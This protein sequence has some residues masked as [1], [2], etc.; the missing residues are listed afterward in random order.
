MCCCCFLASGTKVARKGCRDRHRRRGPTLGGDNFC[1]H[2][3][4]FV[5]WLDPACSVW[6]LDSAVRSIV[7]GLAQAASA[8]K[9]AASAVNAAAVAAVVVAAAAAAAAAVIRRSILNL[10]VLKDIS[11]AIGRRTNDNVAEPDLVSLARHA[12][13][14]V[15]EQADAHA[16]E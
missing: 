15:H 12:A 13:T 11:R 2:A 6:R 5:G 3:W 14:D 7:G 10:V 1:P 9:P 8:Y 16:R 4:V